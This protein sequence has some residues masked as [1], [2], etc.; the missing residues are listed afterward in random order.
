MK[1]ITTGTFNLTPSMRQRINRVLDSGRI[2]YGEQSLELERRFAALHDCRYAILSNS[3]TSA[4][5]IALQTLKEVHGWHDGDEVLVPATT[6]VATANV[7]LHNRLT[8]VLVDV[9]PDAFGMNPALVARVVTARTRA[10][11]PVHLFGQPCD[12]R[13]ICQAA[14]TYNLKIIED[15]C[16]AMFVENDGKSVG[17]MGDIGC[18]SFYMAHLIVAGVGGIATTNNPDYA[19]KMR[20]LV[21]HGLSIDNLNPDENFAPRPMLGRRF[22]FDAIGH[23]FRLTEFE[24]ALALAQLDEREEMLAA[25]RRN[26]KHLAAGIAI[27]TNGDISTTRQLMHSTHAHMMFPL[28]VRPEPKEALCAWL[29]EHGIETRD[30]PSLLYQ[31]CYQW[32]A[33]KYPVSKLIATNGFYVGCHQ[34]MT[35]ED[36]QAIVYCIATYFDNTHPLS[37]G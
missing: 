30:I 20:S 11:I 1:Q 34:G 2:S 26:A 18:F 28:I 4:L 8:P 15:S 5:H 27:I 13:G 14:R 17:S 23:S 10:I 22:A 24:A 25:R 29:N 35:G 16:E 37:E 9:E 7:V 21:N 12:M 6:F 19:A 36:C 33:N 3:G 32:D 31:P